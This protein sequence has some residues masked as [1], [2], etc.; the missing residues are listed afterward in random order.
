MSDI[1][2]TDPKYRVDWRTISVHDDDNIKGFFSDY[3]YLSNF[4]PA[5]VYYEGAQYPSSENA[6]MSAKT[7]DLKLREEFTIITAAQAKKLGRQITLR[8]GWEE[9]KLDVMLEV[10]FSKFLRNKD[11]RKKLVETGNKYLEE[12]NAWRDTYWG[13]DYQLGGS[14]HLGKILTKIRECLK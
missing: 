4:F 5:A 14:N 10:C 13:V 8:E 6:F 3:R 1:Y 2:Y 7:T 11:L 12:T 9:M